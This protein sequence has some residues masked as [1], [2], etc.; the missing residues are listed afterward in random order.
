MVTFKDK[1]KKGVYNQTGEICWIKDYFYKKELDEK[2]DMV[3]IQ[4]NK[5]GYTPL[6][7]IVPASHVEQ[8]DWKENENGSN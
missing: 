4:Y 6:N 1:G 5:A 8:I 7:K 3:Y 2:E